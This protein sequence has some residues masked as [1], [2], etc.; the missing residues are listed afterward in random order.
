M[1][2]D[3]KNLAVDAKTTNAIVGAEPEG[4]EQGVGIF[5]AETAQL[6]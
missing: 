3:R 4:N 5:H 1:R 2:L 6:R